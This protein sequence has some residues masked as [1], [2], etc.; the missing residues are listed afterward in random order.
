MN[1]RMLGYLLGIILSTEAALLLIP[2]GIALIYQEPCWYF[3][4]TTA[5]LAAVALP[6]LLQ[7]PKNNGF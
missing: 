2:A 1:Y 3:L 5:I 4:L 7:R 6:L